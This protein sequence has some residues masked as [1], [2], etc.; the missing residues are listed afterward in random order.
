MS[1]TN[2]VRANGRLTEAGVSEIHRLRAA[3]HT[4]PAIAKLVGISNGTVYQVCKGKTQRDMH[5][6]VH[7]YPWA[8][9][10]AAE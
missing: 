1:A 7:I 8:P 5:P 9:A 2:Y 10:T 4:Y 6:T 3:G